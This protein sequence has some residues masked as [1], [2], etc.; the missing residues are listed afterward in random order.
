MAGFIDEAVLDEILGRSDIVEL[1][2]SYIPLKKSGRNFKACC[3]FHKEKTAS[4]MVSA[5]K[6]IYHCFGCHAGGNAFNFL[7]QYERMEFPEAVEFL[8][9]KTGVILPQ[10]KQVQA[11]SGLVSQAYKINELACEF[12][13]GILR[14]AQAKAAQGYLSKRG[15]S[16]GTAKEFRLGFARDSWD[17]LLKFLAS[18]KIDAA[19][20]QKAG[21]VLPG[22][23]SGHYDRFRNRIIFPISDVKSMVI[24]FGARVLDDSLPKYIN[25]PETPVYVK[26]SHLFG[27][28]LAKEAIR[29]QDLAVVVEGYLDCIMPFQA[30]MKNIVASLGT[31]LT[32]QQA[33]LLKRYTHNVCLVYDPDTAGQDASL[34]SLEIFIDEGIDLKI[35]LLPEGLD[36]DLFVKK[37]GLDGFKKLV[38]NALS[39]FDFKF[40]YL[41]RRRSPKDI[42]NKAYICDE[43][44][45]TI[46][47]FKN[48]VLRS[49]YLR[50]LSDALDIDGSALVERLNSVKKDNRGGENENAPVFAK[51]G[52][53]PTE[54]LL[55]KLLLEEQAV[56][57]ELRDQID[58]LDFQD[59][60]ISKIVHLMLELTADGSALSANAIFNRMGSDETMRLICESTFLPDVADNQK[61]HIINDCIKRLKSAR[62]LSRRQQLQAQIKSAQEK[63]DSELLNDL[64][65]EF[66]SLI[67]KG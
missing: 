67:K 48:A 19:A 43:M 10:K 3:P 38:E 58:P 50:K 56:L 8:A 53:S 51:S 32:P 42:Q 41:T 25:S 36:P 4:F 12:Y 5:D 31:A 35:A 55:I 14:S 63:G 66:Q 13:S 62:I 37:H 17:D 39:I 49:E 57:Q 9:R 44:L 54:Q 16:P 40:D 64:F 65:L 33:R 2:S 26:G 59:S 23:N 7:M 20:A 11:P 28:N 15:I 60:R 24:G 22:Q 34:R 6:Q 47:R 45:S 18:K 46:S 21:L 52:A 61:K 30:G 1:I 29:Q 27:L